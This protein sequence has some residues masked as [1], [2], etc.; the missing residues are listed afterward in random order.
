M[1][2][3]KAEQSVHLLLNRQLHVIMV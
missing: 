3:D 2:L 1:T